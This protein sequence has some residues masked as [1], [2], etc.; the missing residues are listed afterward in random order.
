MTREVALPAGTFRLLDL[1]GL[2]RAKQAMG[3]PHDLL[4]VVQLEAIRERRPK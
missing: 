1:D 2:I 3:R 4:A